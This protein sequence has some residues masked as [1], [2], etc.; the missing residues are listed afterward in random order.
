MKKSLV[1]V[2]VLVGFLLIGLSGCGDDGSLIDIRVDV[3]SDG[4]VVKSPLIVKGE[5]KGVWF[6]EGVF[7]VELLNSDGEV[8]ARSQAHANGD[9]MTDED[10]KFEAELDFLPETTDGELILRKDNPSGLPENDAQVRIPVK[11][12]SSDGF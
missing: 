3:P 12:T 7:P 5:A 1:P 6:F 4:D 10:V 2:L 9:W 11:F 8:I